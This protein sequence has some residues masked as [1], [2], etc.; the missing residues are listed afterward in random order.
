MAVKLNKTPKRTRSRKNRYSK[1]VIRWL[2][3]C[4]PAGLLMMWSDRCRWNRVVKSSVSLGIA[5]VLIVLISPLTRPP[6]R[7]TGGIETVSREPVAELVGPEYKR[8]G[9]DDLEDF[10]FTFIQPESIV[11]EPTPTPIPTYVYCNTGGKNYHGQKCKFVKP[12]SARVTLNQAMAQG[13]TQ[14][15]KCDAPGEYD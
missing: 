7:A 14:C 3:F 13:F 11:V 2:V 10:A 6:V 15:K 8:G 12:T 5:L 1:A 9:A 4:F